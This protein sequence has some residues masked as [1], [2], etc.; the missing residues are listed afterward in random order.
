MWGAGAG[1]RSLVAGPGNEC[2]EVATGDQIT[3]TS[4]NI[5]TGGFSRDSGPGDRSPDGI[6]KWRPLVIDLESIKSNQHYCIY[7]V[8]I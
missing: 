7:L 6:R 1:S 8:S 4:G 3:E 2:A 5:L